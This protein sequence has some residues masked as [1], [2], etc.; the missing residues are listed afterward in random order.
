MELE[1][2]D[3]ARGYITFVGISSG[4]AISCSGASLMCE[5]ARVPVR[6]VPAPSPGRLTLYLIEPYVPGL[7]GNAINPSADCGEW[8]KINPALA[9]HVR[10]R[11][12][13]DI[14]NRIAIADEER[15]R[16]QV[17]FHYA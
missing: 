1:P 14:C 6:C 5:V 15:S 4:V 11:V 9:R 3:G 17:P 10:I 13:G 8:S 16:C 12:E 2:L 7:R